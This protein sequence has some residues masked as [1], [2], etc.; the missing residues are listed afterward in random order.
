VRTSPLDAYYPSMSAKTRGASIAMMFLVALLL[1]PLAVLL[2]GK[3]FQAILNCLLTLCF[4]FPG[5]LHAILVVSSSHADRRHREQMKA[6]Q[7]QTESLQRA[8]EQTG[9]S[10]SSVRPPEPTA[11]QPRKGYHISRPEP[12]QAK[13]QKVAAPTKPP[14]EPLLARVKTTLAAFKEATWQAYRELPE[15]AQPITWGLAAGSA[16]SFLV[17]AFLLWR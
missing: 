14:G 13:P 7:E 6:I 12:W 2:C 16:V 1:P 15:W 5:A 17:V 3:P 9:G 11:E 4:Y 8:M 10:T